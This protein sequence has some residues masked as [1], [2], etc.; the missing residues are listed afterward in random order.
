MDWQTSLKTQWQLST[1]RFLKA[2]E[3]VTPEEAA[4]R[5]QDLTPITWQV[6]HTAYYDNILLRRAGL[7]AEMP[8]AYEELFPIGTDGRGALPSLDEV[9]EFFRES[10]RRIAAL[11]D[12]PEALARPTEGTANYSTLGEGVMYIIGHRGYHRGKIMTLRGLLG[13]PRLA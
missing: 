11:L 5:P 9:R 4:A 2:I 6:G 7:T 13:K 10:S 3:D 1:D 8:A 12:D